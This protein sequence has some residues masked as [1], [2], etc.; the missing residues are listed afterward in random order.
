MEGTL[1]SA[2]KRIYSML[3]TGAFLVGALI[4]YGSLIAPEY[5]RLIALRGLVDAKK[6]ALAEQ[7]KI[8]N[9]VKQALAKYASD[10]TLQK[11]V[12]LALPQDR[13][14]STALQQIQALASAN[15]LVLQ[16]F[17]VN[18][19]SLKP[20]ESNL[21]VAKK[22][23]TL[24]INAR[25]VGNYNSFKEFARGVETNVRVMDLTQT[26]FQQASGE[27]QNVYVYDVVIN[28]YYQ[29]AN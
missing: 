10:E 12:S 21:K 19:L 28:A 5:N 15:G 1:A 25:L 26:R 2:K 6:E 4:F 3:A 9:Q 8:F 20:S 18:D 13:A 22:V 11:T 23:G 27:R 14:V 16:S 17:G 29:A 24:Q 7:Q